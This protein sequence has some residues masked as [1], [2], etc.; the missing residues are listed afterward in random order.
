[1]VFALCL[2]INKV[3]HTVLLHLQLH[4]GEH[5]RLAFSLCNLLYKNILDTSDT[6]IQTGCHDVHELFVQANPSGD[7]TT[8]CTTACQVC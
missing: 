8:C 4:C 1:M 6:V 5:A 7:G 3:I 2:I